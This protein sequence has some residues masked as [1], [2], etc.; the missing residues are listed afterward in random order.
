MKIRMNYIDAPESSQEGGQESK[1]FLKDTMQD[2]VDSQNGPRAPKL[3]VRV[4]GKDRYGRYLGVIMIGR[5]DVNKLM[6]KSGHAWCYPTGCP[7]GYLNGMK[8]ARKSGIGLWEEKNPTAPWVYR[9]Q[10]KKQG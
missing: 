5:K 9:K 1:Q 7:S 8:K 3:S 6:V 4:Y 10:S 2:F